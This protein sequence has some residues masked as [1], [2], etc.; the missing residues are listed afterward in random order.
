MAN[1]I[2][3]DGVD[4]LNK[5]LKVGQPQL[6]KWALQITKGTKLEYFWNEDYGW[7]SGVVTEDPVTIVDEILLTIRFEDSETHK[8]P[9]TA[10][11]K[12]RR[13]PS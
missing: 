13:R 8:L 7:C 6:P 5:D 4:E 3:D 11:D 9:R 10:E 2:T 1:Q 12:I